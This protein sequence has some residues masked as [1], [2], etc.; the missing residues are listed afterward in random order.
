MV[1]LPSPVNAQQKIASHLRSRRLAI[2]LTQEGLSRRS[3]VPL[4]TLRKFEQQGTI[5][6]EAFLKL[7]M[8]VGGLDDLVR[9]LEPKETEFKSIEDVLRANE[10]KTTRKRG[11]RV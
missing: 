9:A 5:S 1:L 6:L 3:G 10:A 8:V 2:E 4:S 11:R 7:L